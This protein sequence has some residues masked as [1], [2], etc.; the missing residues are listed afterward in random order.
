VIT[1]VPGEKVE[2]LVNAIINMPE[3]VK[4]SLSFLVRKPGKN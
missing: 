4:E 3:D 2:K 1:P